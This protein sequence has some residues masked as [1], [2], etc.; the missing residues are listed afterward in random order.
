MRLPSAM[1]WSSRLSI[2][3][4]EPSPGSAPSAD[5]SNGRITPE[6]EKGLTPWAIRMLRTSPA[7]STAPTSMA[8]ASFLWS[9]RAAMS[10]ALKPDAALA[11]TVKLGAPMPNSLATR[12]ATTPAKAPSVREAF[13]AGPKSSFRDSSQAALWVS[14]RETPACFNHSVYVLPRLHLTW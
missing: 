11:E 3:A 10:R 9:R 12:L 2:T 13:S 8:S 6:G 7:M 5:L 4:A 14:F 1:A